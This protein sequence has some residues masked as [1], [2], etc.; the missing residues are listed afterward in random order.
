MVTHTRTHTKVGFAN[1]FLV[2]DKCKAPVKYWHNPERCG[3]DEE[4]FNYPCN[5]KTGVTSICPSWSPIDGCSCPGE[6]SCSK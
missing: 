1:P 3:C 4:Y 6:S 2:C 5:H